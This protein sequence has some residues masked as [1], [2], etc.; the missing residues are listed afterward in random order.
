MR[1]RLAP[2]TFLRVCDWK[3]FSLR[4]ECFVYETIARLAGVFA[5]TCAKLHIRTCSPSHSYGQRVPPAG[6]LPIKA[7]RRDTVQ[8]GKDSN[9]SSSDQQTSASEKDKT[10][11]T[12]RTQAASCV[13]GVA[14]QSQAKSS[15]YASKVG[16]WSFSAPWNET[17]I[18]CAVQIYTQT[19]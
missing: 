14:A 10:V 13:K 4:T 3:P 11:R 18:G 15:N 1:A 5:V 17:K 16:A 8:L 7:Q 19:A 2:K 6:S 12:N 9:K